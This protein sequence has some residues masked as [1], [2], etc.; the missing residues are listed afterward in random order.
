[1][2]LSFLQFI[3]DAQIYLINYLFAPT[4]YSTDVYLYGLPD[5]IEKIDL[6]NR[7]ITSLPDLSRFY[8][9]HEL[10]IS[11]NLLTTLPPL[12]PNLK[13]LHCSNNTL[14][15]LPILPLTLKVL[16]CSHNQLTSL[17]HLAENLEHLYCWR[18]QLTS[19]PR[20]P[21]S[22][23]SLHCDYNRLY[24]LPPI[25]D[26]LMTFQFHDNPIH[27][28]ILFMRR[29]IIVDNMIILTDRR[30]RFKT[31]IEIL[32]KFR[33]LYYSLT[34]KKRFRYWLW[35]RVREPKIREK[36]SPYNLLKLIDGFEDE[37]LVDDLLR[38][39]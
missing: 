3:V 37:E 24:Y 38:N 11:C 32:N 4:V 29:K 39:W 33:H 23:R 14:T 30:S 6:S 19:L 34:F 31:E 21:Q 1:M 5:D 16:Y 20:L 28:E 9:L 36:Y 25:P 8:N 22:L 35:V 10:F 2:I 13:M 26:S 12:P 7:N 27:D 17:P 15:T 18:N